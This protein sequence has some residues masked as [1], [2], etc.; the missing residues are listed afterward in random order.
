[1]V[2]LNPAYSGY[3]GNYISVWVP[4]TIS[5][6]SFPAAPQPFKRPSRRHLRYWPKSVPE[7]NFLTLGMR[8]DVT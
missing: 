8:A 5:F 1:M 2:P 3:S 7:T 4:A 6:S